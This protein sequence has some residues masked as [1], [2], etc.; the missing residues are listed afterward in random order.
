MSLARI[1]DNLFH[2]PS[3]LVLVLIG[4]LITAEA[5]IFLF[6]TPMEF[7]MD[8]TY[9][10]FVYADNLITHGKLFFSDA[11][12]TGVGSTSLLWVFLLAGLK[13]LGIPF[14][15]SAK[16]M[17]SLGLM[18]VT[19]GFY[20][21]LRPAWKSPFLLLGILLISISGNLIWISL[22]GMETMLFFA[23]GILALLA[24]QHKKWKSL[25][26]LLGLMILARPEGLIL[27]AVLMVVDMWINRG[28]R[29]ELVMVGLLCA[30][31]SAPWFIYLYLR[32]GYLLP[33]S[34]IGKQLTFFIGMDYVAAQNP[35]LATLLQLRNVVYPF[36]WLTYLLVFALGGK[37]LP[38]PYLMEGN[39]F[40]VM[41]Y[42]PSFWAVAGWVAIIFPLLFV[43]SRDLLAGKK[44]LP[45][46]LDAKSTPVVIFALWVLSHNLAYMLFMPVIG[47][48]S[49][50]GVMNHAAL[51]I[52][53][54]VGASK[55]SQRAYLNSF[56][57]G[58]L[59]VIALANNLYWNRVYDANIEH[60][61]NVRIATAHFLRDSIPAQ[62]R[63]A[64]FDIGAVRYF[65][66]RPIVD[67]GGLI[68]P[69]EIQWFRDHKS[70]EYLVAAGVTCIIIP[71]QSNLN[72]EGWIDF[73]KLLSL[74]HT[75]L[76]KL[77]KIATFEMDSERWLLG[78]LP[79]ANQ[80]KS[81]DIYRLIRTK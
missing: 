14:F 19:A 4:G 30:V 6:P 8:D 32:T 51:W 59:F 60:M 12:E 70:A 52:L 26:I 72:G 15:I 62:D 54:A 28:L 41:S 11:N 68:D 74:D 43:A 22:S 16:I 3:W 81:V 24:Y 34:A 56:V 44:W 20:A 37:S 21:L 66:Q 65:S 13:L 55:F 78:Y 50:Y 23:L 45:A 18:V 69:D 31:I 48:A 1:K 27:F 58:G 64:V 9:I 73:L 80:Q 7:P 47:T 71:G 63:C 29:R 2:P 57:T 42:A 40:G 17:G 25:G 5:V 33:S 53:L 10:H 38:P 49:R 39:A 79:T 36:T 67:I 77:E 76:F 61:Q 46:A 75:S 35:Y